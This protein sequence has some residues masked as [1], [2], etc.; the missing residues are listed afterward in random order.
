M[1]SAPNYR[2]ADAYINNTVDERHKGQSPDPF[3]Q[4]FKFNGNSLRGNDYEFKSQMREILSQSDYGIEKAPPSETL[5]DKI[6]NRSE[7]IQDQFNDQKREMITKQTDGNDNRVYDSINPYIHT[8]PVINP[9]I[10]KRP[11]SLF[12][13]I[14][15]TTVLVVIGV[16]LCFFFIR[17]LFP[18]EKRTVELPGPAVGNMNITD[19][20]LITEPETMEN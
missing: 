13:S 12:D 8:Y 5:I 20:G 16:V 14:V 6:S 3:S 10:I 1:W 9:Y 2:L 19:D 4:S 11:P 15:T 7:Y 17:A 18:I